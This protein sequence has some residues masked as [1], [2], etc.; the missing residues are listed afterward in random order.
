MSIAIFASG[1]GS[2][3]EAVVRYSREHHWT[4]PV[5]LL[6]VD[7][8]DAGAI[9]RAKRLE[10]P[11]YVVS[12]KRF[13]NKVEY[14]KKLLE[15]LTK[16]GVQWIVLAGYLRIVGN[17]L[18]EPFEGRMVNIHPSLLPSFPGL[19][20]IEQAWAYGVR[21]TGVTVHFV[22]AGLDS[23]P[24]IVQRAV[25]VDSTDSIDRLRSKIHKAEHRI[26]PETVWKVVTGEVSYIPRIS[27]V[28][29]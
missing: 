6:V 28:S 19:H 13:S 20:A 12:P 10:V 23:G 4:T 1:N 17:T 16:H 15:L 18:L 25:E 21:V 9:D 3:F 26:Y 7:R 8:E 14:E 2:N 5:S 11:C 24:I 22:D 29:S 27:V